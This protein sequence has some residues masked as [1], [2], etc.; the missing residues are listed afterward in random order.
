MFAITGDDVIVRTKCRNRTD[1][2]RLLSDVEVAKAANLAHAVRLS[3]LFLKPPD[4]QHL[5]KHPKQSLTVLVEDCLAVLV[6]L[7]DNA[8]RSCVCVLP[9]LRCLAA[10]VSLFRLGQISRRPADACKG[11]TRLYATLV[12]RQVLT[13]SNFIST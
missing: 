11:E 2:D 7:I 10:H 8:C 9:S 4:Q 1:R 3:A 13:N 5:V 6:G 12:S